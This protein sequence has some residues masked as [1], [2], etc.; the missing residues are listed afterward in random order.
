MVGKS[1]I[2]QRLQFTEGVIVAPSFISAAL[3]Y[4]PKVADSRMGGT[5]TPS[6]RFG[7]ADGLI[8]YNFKKVLKIIVGKYCA[9]S[10][11][12]LYDEVKKFEN[13]LT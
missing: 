9:T 5:V 1:R 3:G 2:Y 11:T 6:K 7:L 12:Y 4:V 13:I 8:F 10:L